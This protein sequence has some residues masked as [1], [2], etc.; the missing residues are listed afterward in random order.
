MSTLQGKSIF[1]TYKDLLQVSNGNAGV[2]DT[3]R[4]I[5]DGEGTPSIL[6]LSTT[7]VGIGTTNPSAKLDIFG[8][9]SSLKFT[10][11]AGD[12][13]AE[14]LY[15]GT[16]FLIKAPLGDRL[17]ITDSSSNE[18]LTVNPNSGN[19]GIGTTNPDVKLDVHGVGYFRTPTGGALISSWSTGASTGENQPVLLLRT[20]ETSDADRIKLNSDGNSY[21]Y[22]GNV[23]IGTTT[24]G[25]KLEI[26]D[27]YQGYDSSTTP[28]RSLDV[29]T[30]SPQNS[31]SSIGLESRSP[32]N[33]D[34]SISTI[35][36]VPVGNGSGALAFGTRHQYSFNERM[37]IDSSGNVGIGT[38]SPSSSYKLHVA[39]PDESRILIQRTTPNGD[40]SGITLHSVAGE[41]AGVTY[42]S[43]TGDIRFMTYDQ[44]PDSHGGLELMTNNG[45]GTGNKIGLRVT[46]GICQKPGNPAFYHRSSEGDGNGLST[47][48][49]GGG[50]VYHNTG[51]H[52]N[53][54]TGRFT[55]P[56]AGVYFFALW[57]QEEGY[58]GEWGSPYGRFTVNGVDVRWFGGDTMLDS[59]TSGEQYFNMHAS[60]Y[61]NVGDYVQAFLYGTNDTVNTSI[62]DSMGGFEG[63]FIG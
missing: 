60:I 20:N 50:T 61:L 33:T 17:S 12:R 56:V 8:S 59:Q 4:Y 43:R 9:N 14:M 48:F 54:T 38:T 19:V 11:D 39:D 51:N 62:E 16:K 35:T 37:R 30:D 41:S 44:I 28:N 21:F 25:A 3:A 40:V 1:N 52:Y 46:Q 45:D 63:F 47:G 34:A 18:L 36:C 22:G 15:D 29:R 5:E 10:R 2:D 55:A 23:G 7:R 58:Y 57:V 6:S 42:N 53:N 27:S 49:R 32:N 31:Y 24:P 13:S 26:L